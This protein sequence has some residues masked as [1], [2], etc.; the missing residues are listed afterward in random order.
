MKHRELVAWIS[1]LAKGDCPFARPAWIADKVDVIEFRRDLLQTI[2][3]LGRRV[4]RPERIV[5]L[6]FDPD[7]VTTT[8]VAD[9]VDAANIFLRHQ[10]RMVLYT[11]PHAKHHRS[12]PTL[13][14]VF[15]Q[16]LSEMVDAARRLASTSY[17][18]T[19]PYPEWAA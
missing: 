14:V 9:A 3:F 2:L 7:R 10:D 6:C 11:H 17:Y 12:H 5:L 13:G 4:L 18:D 1:E 8:S 16:F 15:I 19:R